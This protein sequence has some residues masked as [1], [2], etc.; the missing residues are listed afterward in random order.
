M[1]LYN[2]GYGRRKLDTDFKFY[3]IKDQINVN[4]ISNLCLDVGTKNSL[5]KFFQIQLIT[6]KFIINLSMLSD[7]TEKF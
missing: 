7:D 2:D 1:F 4:G 6:N 5:E 3:L